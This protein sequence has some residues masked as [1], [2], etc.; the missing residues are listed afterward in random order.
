[1]MNVDESTMSVNDWAYVLL[2]FV[3]ILFASLCVGGMLDYCHRLIE[4]AG[5]I[6]KEDD[7]QKYLLHHAVLID[8]GAYL[9]AGRMLAF[10]LERMDEYEL[11]T[12]GNLLGALFLFCVCIGGPIIKKRGSL[13]VALAGAYFLTWGIIGPAFM[14]LPLFLAFVTVSVILSALMLQGLTRIMVYMEARERTDRG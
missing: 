14:L 3:A 7:E 6:S 12:S 1:M 2:T 5:N 4:N 8:L 9:V 13:A 11:E 10:F